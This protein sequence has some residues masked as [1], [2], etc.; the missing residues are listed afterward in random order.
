MLRNLLHPNKMSAVLAPE[1]LVAYD[2][3]PLLTGQWELLTPNHWGVIAGIVTY[4]MTVSV[5]LILLVMGGTFR[6]LR[7]ESAE[8]KVKGIAAFSPPFE[9][10]KLYDELLEAAARLPL[11][12]A[13]G[14]D[15]EAASPSIKGGTVNL[16]PFDKA[17]HLTVL[18]D[19]SNGGPIYAHGPYDPEAVVWRF[20]SDGPFESAA[21]FGN[22]ALLLDD[23]PDGRRFV[24]IDKTTGYVVG[25]IS[26]LENSPHDLRCRVGDMWLTPA[27]QRTH[28]STDAV[29]TLLTHLFSQGYR[30]V[31]WRCD[32]EDGRG[33]RAA[34]RLGF[35][36][37]GV[38]RKH[39]VVRGCNAD[40]A[41][42][43]MTNSD[44]RDFQRERL[45]A[46]VRPP[47]GISEPTRQPGLVGANTAKTN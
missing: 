31:E 30:R 24:I 13:A 19:I 21:A 5:V 16:A 37:E 41:L 15:A 44:W 34:E 36:L 47:T 14:P 6:R 12:P 27:F 3:R 43:T 38:L 32:A 1:V 17:A 33:R 20:L 46:L 11:K 35:L 10:F 8:F 42:Y 28:A 4:V 29:L 9:R 39:G 23:R 25:M 18:H 2:L 45:Q 7:E 22:S 40:A 26:V